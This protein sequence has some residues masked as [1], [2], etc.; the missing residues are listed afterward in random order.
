MP[1]TIVTLAD[2]VVAQLNSTTFSLP[3]NA[4]RLYLPRFDLAQ[5]TTL[6][7][8][9]VPK[10]V[11]S[12]GLDRA[13]DTFDY[14]LDIAIQQKLEPTVTNLDPLMTL[15]EEIADHLRTQRLAAFPEAR[16]V[17]V[18]NV[19]VYALEHLDE[20]RAFTSVVTPTFKLWR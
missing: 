18:E 8:S 7:V 20:F 10:S 15:V 3:F 16:C 5:M 11:T 9:V 6:H 13:R 1:A 17:E 19:P 4:T 14:R 2:A 12:K